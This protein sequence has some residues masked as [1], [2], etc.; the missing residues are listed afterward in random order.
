MLHS[1]HQKQNFRENNVIETSKTMKHL[2]QTN[3]NFL[4]FF[5][6]KRTQQVDT[7]P[8]CFKTVD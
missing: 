6:R 4:T 8:L 7:R 2:K 1:K 3:L 5:G